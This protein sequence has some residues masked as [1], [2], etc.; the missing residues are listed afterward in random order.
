[1]K[2]TI[3]ITV[4]NEKN[5]ILKAIADAEAI[6]VDKEIIIVDNCSV[7]GTREILRD[8]K[9][10]PGTRII[11]QPKNYGYGQSVITGSSEANGEFIYMQYSDL[12]YDIECVYRMLEIAEKENLDIVFGSRLYNKRSGSLAKASIIKQRP[13]Y[14]GTLITTFLVNLFF[15]RNFTD[16]IGVRLYRA[17]S[18]SKIA[19][20]SGD[21]YFDFEAISKFCKAG[22]KIREIPVSYKP[23]KKGKKVKPWG[24]FPAVFKIFKVKFSNWPIFKTGINLK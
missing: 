15:K 8:L 22:F 4:Y 2:L 3:I 20:D 9:P 17:S 13:Y 7:D 23:R 1:M 24:I 16:I 10:G 11:F 19:I 5:T 18:F 12:E 14:L 21:L 6:A